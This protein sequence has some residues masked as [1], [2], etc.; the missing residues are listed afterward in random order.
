[1]TNNKLLYYIWILTLI[2]VFAFASN[3]IDPDFWAR[4][5]QGDAFWQLGHILKSDI[6]SYTPTHMWYDHE[7][8][9]SI[10]FSFILRHFGYC[11]IFLLRVLLASFIVCFIFKSIILKTGKAFNPF[12]IG[13]F[14]LAIA[15][16]P[17]IYFSALRCHF[18]TFLLFTVFI[19]ILE[20]VRKNGEN[21]LLFLLPFLMLIWANCH[22]GCVSALGLLSIYTIGEALNKKPFKNYIITLFVCFLVMFINPY[23]IDYVKFIF[24]AS[25][26]PRPFVTE[27]V[28]PFS[29]SN[30]ML[31]YFKIFYL[32]FITLLIIRIKDYK[33]DI[34]KYFLLFVCAYLSFVYIKNIPFF[35][36]TS[37]IFLYPDICNWY[38]EIIEKRK[39]KIDMN[40]FILYEKY[41]V[42]RFIFVIIFVV[43]GFVVINPPLYYLSEQP[44]SQ[45]EFFK[46]NNL[47]GKILAPMELGS[48][49]AYK[50]FPNNLI[51]MDGRYEEVY[52]NKEKELL[53]K[54]YNAQ[55]G[56][57]EILKEPYKPDYII[58]PKDALI[59]DYIPSEYKSVYNDNTYIIYSLED[60][61]K[62]KYYIPAS[63]LN[64]DYYLRN[65][66]KKGFDFKKIDKK[67]L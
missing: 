39:D 42:S 11:G 44:V 33:N 2:I 10:I 20:R 55:E 35:M 3:N 15:A 61:I 27:W 54:F 32:F 43:V 52:F 46:I 56:W 30:E 63:P 5:I 49:L 4:I 40:A 58:V 50:L 65:A 60:K 67:S 12:D 8:G 29:S 23:G 45:A 62:S 64:S 18:I 17:S 31:V 48:Y 19:Y 25:T 9:A 59:N 7:W 6:F 47:N 13:V 51:Y 37:L 34:T 16:M 57:E 21:R 41:W 1:M 24:M 14:T 66:F 36:I 26:M 28:S 38:Y 53:D 22:G